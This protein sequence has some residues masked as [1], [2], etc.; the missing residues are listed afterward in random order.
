VAVAAM[1]APSAKAQGLS[2][3][4]D[5]RLEIADITYPGAR[6]DMKGYLASPRRAARSR[7]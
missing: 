1:I 5:E 4:T 3:E 7:R 2:S 6:G